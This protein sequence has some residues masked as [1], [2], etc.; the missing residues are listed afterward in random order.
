MRHLSSVVLVS[1]LVLTGC[2]SIFGGLTLDGS[3]LGEGQGQAELSGETQI[4]L[5]VEAELTFDDAEADQ[6]V[7]VADARVTVT[8]SG[9]TPR[10]YVGEVDGT[11]RRDGRFEVD[12]NPMDDDG[13]D[14]RFD[15]E[16]EAT[17]DRIT[18]RLSVIAPGFDLPARLEIEAFTLTR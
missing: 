18:G 5:R 6:G 10:V 17:D 11:L 15:I 16:G 4:A 12:G 7:I 2:D 9:G 1:L 13:A 8:P 14:L 3:Y